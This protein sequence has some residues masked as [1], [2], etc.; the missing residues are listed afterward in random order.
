MNIQ[1]VY[2]PAAKAAAPAQPEIFENHYVKDGKIQKN[3]LDFRASSIEPIQKRY[4]A[5]K[6]KTQ[7]WTWRTPF[8]KISEVFTSI[9]TSIGKVISSILSC[10]S[11][12]KT[13]AKTDDIAKKV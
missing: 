13:E 10:C 2:N 6:A 4:D 11:Y 5:E 8:Q 9:W 3:A 7:A 1:N 12:G